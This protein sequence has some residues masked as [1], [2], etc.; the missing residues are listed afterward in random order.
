[1]PNQ[2]DTRHPYVNAND[3]Y[4]WITLKFF[5]NIKPVLIIQILSRKKCIVY[6]WRD[7][8]LIFKM[9]IKFVLTTF[10]G[11]FFPGKYLTFSCVSLMIS[12]NFLPSMS[13]SNTYMVTR[14]SK[15][16]RRAALTPTILAIAD[17]LLIENIYINNKFNMCEL[18]SF[19]GYIKQIA[20][21]IYIQVSI[22]YYV[23]VIFNKNICVAVMTLINEGF[24]LCIIR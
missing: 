4:Y 15:F 16:E 14:S 22:N 18:T 19:V 21:Y 1:M 7:F 11:N 8:F 2:P 24:T 13:S 10:G 23:A 9:T 3:C 12:V 20:H 6:F 17:P 5:H